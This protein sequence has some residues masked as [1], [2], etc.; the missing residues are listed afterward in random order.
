MS[1]ERAR[2]GNVSQRWGLLSPAGLAI[3]I[4][5]LLIVLTS[6]SETC[7]RPRL[8]VAV[9]TKHENDCQEWS[10]VCLDQGTIVYYGKRPVPINYTDYLGPIVY[11]L[12]DRC[13]A[14]FGAQ[15]AAATCHGPVS[16]AALCATRKVHGERTFAGA[17][18]GNR[19]A[20][21]TVSE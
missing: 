19:H 12:P 6:S 1:G 20:V 9:A 21:S 3:F 2:T 18:T 16:D 5:A 10:D 8:D 4:I 13:V 17:P 11:N 15:R 14:R 7:Q